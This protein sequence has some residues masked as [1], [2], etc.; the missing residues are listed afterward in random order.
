VNW[1]RPAKQ[2]YNRL[3]GFYPWP[4]AYTTFRGQ[5]LSIVRAKPV[6]AAN[7]SPA[8]LRSDTRRL[9]A[10]CGENSALELIEIQLAGKKNMT[11]DAFLNG[12]RP[13]ENERL[14]DPN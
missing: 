12:Y 8:V 3:R 5:Q 4:G 14:G 7:L 6:E 13:A 2:I 10:G 11:V 9:L 1:S